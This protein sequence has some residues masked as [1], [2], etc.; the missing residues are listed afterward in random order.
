[1]NEKRL[2]ESVEGVIP[3]FSEK[4]KQ[5]R[6]IP[7]ERGGQYGISPFAHRNSHLFVVEKAK[8]AE[9][10]ERHN[11]DRRRVRRLVIQ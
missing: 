11:A 5:T 4:A 7:R 10:Q 1:M 9:R 2:I 3:V 6:K 8:K